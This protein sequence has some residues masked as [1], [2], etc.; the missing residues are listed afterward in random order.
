MLGASVT[1]ERVSRTY[2]GRDVLHDVSFTINPGELVA[3]TGPSGS[4]KT[5][6]LQLIGSLDSPTTGRILVEGVNVGEL[7]GRRSSAAT[8]S[9]SCSRCIICCRV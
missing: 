6:L 2:D 8:R 3:L 4:G 1:V 9:G 5:T 7:R